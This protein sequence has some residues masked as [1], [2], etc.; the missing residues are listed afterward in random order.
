MALLHRQSLLDARLINAIDA[1]R[2]LI[3]L[4]ERRVRRQQ[5]VQASNA[6]A[7]IRREL[8]GPSPGPAE[9]NQMLS[10]K[11]AQSVADYM[12]ELDSTRRSFTTVEGRGEAEPI[13]D[14][15]TEE[16]RAKNRRVVF[17]VIRK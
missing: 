3:G 10:E 2:R 14:N 8:F 16:G 6:I 17:E 4:H 11:R 1:R 5:G 9:Y 13:A 15:G 7:I 12:F